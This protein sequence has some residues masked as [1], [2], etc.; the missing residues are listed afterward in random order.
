MRTTLLLFIMISSF[1]VFGC[2]SGSSNGAG[3]DVNQDSSGDV[4]LDSGGEDGSVSCDTV[5]E[6]KE[7]GEFEGCDCGVCRG[8]EV[9]SVDGICGVCEPDCD[10]LWCGADGCGGSC[11]TCDP[12]TLCEMGICVQDC[13]EVCDGLE[14]GDGGEPECDCGE[15]SE[16]EVCDAGVCVACEPDCEGK[17]CGDDG[18]GG[19]CGDCGDTGGVCVLGQCVLDCLGAIAGNGF[20]DTVQKVNVLE[21]GY[22]GLPGYAL[23]VD[24]NPDSCAPPGN[25]Q[26]GL[27]NS[28]GGAL[29]EIA[30]FV[31]VNKELDAG[32]DSGAVILLA[33]FVSPALDGTAFTLNMY[34]GEEVEPDPLVCNWQADLCDYL[35]EPDSFDLDLCRPVVSFDNITVVEGLLTGGGPDAVFEISMPLVEGAMLTLKARRAKLQ[36]TVVIE[37]GTIIAIE[38]GVIGGAVNK[39][40]VQEACQALP[41]DLFDALGFGKDTVCPLLD[42]IVVADIDTDEDPS[43]DSASVGV[44]FAAIPGNITGLNLPEE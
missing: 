26:D 14:C 29:D 10:G 37:E 33:E 41:D 28:L 5:C 6:G 16:T 1:L 24:D 8:E 44:K 34:A 40:E 22:G 13:S 20:S 4:G 7:C 15:C 12:G 27:D 3:S 17:E 38:D 25:C 31:D 32:L 42:I 30:A 39:V 36:A 35:V 18:C 19:T 43:L 2:S 11:G 9:C 23:D 21:F